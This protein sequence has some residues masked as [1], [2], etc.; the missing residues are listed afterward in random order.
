MSMPVFLSLKYF[1]STPRRLTLKLLPLIYTKDEAI[2]ICRID[3]EGRVPLYQKGLDA[4][5]GEHFFL[6]G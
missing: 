2:E 1:S 6:F 4:I 5:H 3:M